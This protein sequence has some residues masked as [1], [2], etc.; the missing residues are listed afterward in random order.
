MTQVTWPEVVDQCGDRFNEIASTN[1]LVQWAEESLFAKQA[2]DKNPKL[3]Q[4]TMDTVQN[5]IINVA[6]IGL[7]LNSALGYAY[8]VP[9]STK[10][11]NQW[12]NHC[13]LKVSFKGLLKIANESGSIR[14][15]KAEIVREHDVFEYNGPCALPKH[16][17]NA[18]KKDRGPTVG[19]Y[20]I[21]KTHENDHLVDLMD[22]D[23]INKIKAAAK[24][25]MVWDKWFDEMAK[26][27]VIKRASKQWPRKDRSDRIDQAVAIINETEGNQPFEKDITPRIDPAYIGRYHKIIHDRDSMQMVYLI[28]EIKEEYKLTNENTDD[29]IAAIK[30]LRNTFLKGEKGN[31]DAIQEELIRVGIGE[32]SE[33]LS[34]AIQNDDEQAIVECLDGLSYSKHSLALTEDE[35][36]YLKGRK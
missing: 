23:E 6:A 28:D 35:K 31:T 25:S 14:W 15:A 5:S 2:L 1:K 34:I 9:E 29:Y 36:L 33:L 32:I 17:F 27:A 16:S 22:L 13:T 26:K 7:T 20:C 18:F 19:V 24:T 4:C 30:D 3:M 21:A 12:V 8:L 11:G 10:V